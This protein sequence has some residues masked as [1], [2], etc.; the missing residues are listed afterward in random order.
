M[1]LSIKWTLYISNLYQ[2]WSVISY[3]DYIDVQC[4]RFDIRWDILHLCDNMSCY[5][6]NSHYNFPCK[7]LQNVPANTLNDKCVHHCSSCKSTWFHYEHVLWYIN[8]TT[9]ICYYK[10]FDMTKTKCGLVGDLLYKSEQHAP[11][12]FSIYKITSVFV[13]VTLLQM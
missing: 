2:W 7:P 1:Y 9:N 8:L 6:H 4:I 5:L 3:I 13:F 12:T 10:N 11:E